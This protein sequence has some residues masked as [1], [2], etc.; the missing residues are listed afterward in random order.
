M[1]AMSVLEGH[2]DVLTN[3]GLPTHRETEEYLRGNLDIP[4]PK[5]LNLWALPDDP[6]ILKGRSSISKLIKLAIWG[7]ETKRLTLSQIHKAIQERYPT[8]SG[9]WKVRPQLWYMPA[10]CADLAFN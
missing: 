8:I 3:N 7:S 6:N 10:L 4:H 5:P 9:S 1:N 2:G